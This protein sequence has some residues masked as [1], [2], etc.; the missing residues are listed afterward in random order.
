MRYGAWQ[1][2]GRWPVGVQLADTYSPGGADS[3]KDKEL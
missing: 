2:V 1:V 3:S